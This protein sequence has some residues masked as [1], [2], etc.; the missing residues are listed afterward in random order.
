[1]AGDL[2][3]RRVEDQLWQLAHQALD[4]VVAYFATVDGVVQ[5]A[6]WYVYTGTVPTP[7]EH[8]LVCAHT[9]ETPA[10]PGDGQTDRL[11]RGP[12]APR[13]AVFTMWL[14][15]PLTDVLQGEAFTVS[16]AAADPDAADADSRQIL[17]D[18]RVLIRALPWGRT[19]GIF[20]DYSL[21]YV[22]GPVE[23]IEPEGGLGGSKMTFQ[24]EDSGAGSA[25]T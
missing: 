3:V 19:Q 14:W 7:T 10:V 20:G 13:S 25:G 9:L 21:A 23:P 16:G 12:F 1:M 2:E 11:M 22:Q 17:I 24:V 8:T 6:A 18:R 4:A 5:P 15:R